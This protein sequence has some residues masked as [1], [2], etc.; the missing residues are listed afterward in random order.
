M[1][2]EPQIK[3]ENVWAAVK[4]AAASTGAIFIAL[5]A[6][7]VVI[8][9]APEDDGHIRGAAILVGFLPLVLGVLFVYY[10]VLSAREN[11]PLKFALLVQ[12]IIILPFSL[13][14]FYVAFQGAGFFIAAL[15]AFYTF[16]F[17]SVVGSV[18]AWA[19]SKSQKHITKL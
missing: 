8:P 12:T 17:F 14:I 4:G 6:S 5:V 9:S 15:N 11:R 3:S 1:S 10:L 13:F 19:W 7:V 16:A 2:T 18:G